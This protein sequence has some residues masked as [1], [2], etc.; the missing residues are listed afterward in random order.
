MVEISW[1]GRVSYEAAWNM[2]KALV[3][4]RTAAAL[5]DR[6]LLLEHEPVYTLGRSGKEAHLLLDEAQ[7]AAAGI[8]LHWVDRGGDITYHGPGQ[9]VGYPILDLKRLYG[10]RGL[11]RPDLHLYLR[12]IEGVLMAT[13]A[14]FGVRG[15]RYPGYTGVWVDTPAGP[16]KIAAIGVKVNSLG[17]SSHGFALNVDPN[18]DHFAGIVPCGIEEHGVTSLAEC[19]SRPVAIQEVISP[20]VAAFAS[21]FQVETRFATPF[22]SAYNEGEERRRET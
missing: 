8:G 17:I 1:L 18:L 5:P 22:V 14:V 16:R 4:E 3:A 2:Q 20:L 10:N 21:L 15:W 6:L 7:R 11:A 19:L 9:L 13:L 12:E